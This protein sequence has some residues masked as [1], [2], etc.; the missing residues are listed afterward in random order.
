MMAISIPMLDLKDPH[1]LDD[2]LLQHMPL[3]D[4]S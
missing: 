1:A 4:V 2:P 3:I